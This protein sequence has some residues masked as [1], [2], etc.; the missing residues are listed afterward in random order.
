M[1]KEFHWVSMYSIVYDVCLWR[2]SWFS[3]YAFSFL[4]SFLL[5]SS[6]VSPKHTPAVFLVFWG[7]RSLH[8]LL[9]CA[10]CT[11]VLLWVRFCFV[12]LLHRT[13]WTIVREAN[14][15]TKRKKKKKTEK[16]IIHR[17]EMW[18]HDQINTESSNKNPLN[19]MKYIISDFTYQ[20]NQQAKRA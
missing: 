7:L 8:S 16:E 2:T 20:Q 19:W 1:L 14:T 5:L 12:L 6:D 15:E 3:F 9:Q 11:F 10:V 13:C 17:V 4:Y 18:S